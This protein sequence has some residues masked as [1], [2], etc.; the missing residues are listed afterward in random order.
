[1]EIVDAKRPNKAKIVNEQRKRQNT[2]QPKGYQNQSKNV[3]KERI[4]MQWES[5]EFISNYI[6][7]FIDKTSTKM[8]PSPIKSD[9]QL[10]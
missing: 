8:L 3:F 5:F 6:R 1:M 9:R 10:A 7:S 4:N 2:F